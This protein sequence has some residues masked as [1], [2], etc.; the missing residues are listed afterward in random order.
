MTC[1][2][3]DDTQ[4]SFSVFDIHLNQCSLQ[5]RKKNLTIQS[6]KFGQL[7]LKFISSPKEPLIILFFFP[8]LFPSLFNSNTALAFVTLPCLGLN[9]LLPKHRTFTIGLRFALSQETHPIVLPV[10]QNQTRA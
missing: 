7:F 9:L 1:H 3:Q 2:Y 5:E 6:V 10:P 8:Q 4:R